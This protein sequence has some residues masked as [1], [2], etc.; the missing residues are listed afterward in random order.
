MMLP[1]LCGWLGW[2]LVLYDKRRKKYN[3]VE[4]KYNRIIERYRDIKKRK[5][6]L[7]MKL[8]FDKVINETIVLNFLAMSN[9]VYLKLEKGIIEDM[10]YMLY[11]DI[12]D[13]K[14]DLRMKVSYRLIEI[15]SMMTNAVVILYI[16][17]YII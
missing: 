11:K 1:I 5:G 2:K 10:E 14:K 3:Y 4:T 6:N 9:W 12:V 15:L 7:N 16:V 17:I 13:L 8:Q